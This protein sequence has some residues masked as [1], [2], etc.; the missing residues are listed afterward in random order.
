MEIPSW[1]DAPPSDKTKDEIRRAISLV[2]KGKGTP[3]DDEII[4]ACKRST[5]QVF[6][7][8]TIGL[9][10]GI[11]QLLPKLILI[12]FEGGIKV[13]ELGK[14]NYFAD[15]TGQR[16]RTLEEMVKELEPFWK[17]IK[18]ILNVTPGGRQNL[19][20]K[21]SPTD[22]ICLDV[23]YERLKPIWQEAK[24]AA[25]VALKSKEPTRRK[26]WKEEVSA[27]YAEEALPDD[28]IERLAPS[29]DTP[30]ADLALE[31]AGRLCLPDVIP[32]YSLKV[33]KEKLR[34]LK[35]PARTYPDSVKNEGS[36][37]AP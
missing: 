4:A 14:Q 6:E 13:V 36:S 25:R 29:Q 12:L 16:K 33:L 19:R 22:H 31:H 5:L 32:P 18:E 8:H 3:T 9:S 7:A 37:S 1:K 15:Q 23:N 2:S 26:R 27:I 24:K 21:W 35:R 28:L 20:H 17:A 10:V 30:P 34:D 11:S